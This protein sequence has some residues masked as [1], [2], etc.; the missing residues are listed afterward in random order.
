MTAAIEAR[1]V[2]RIYSTPEGSTAALQG[3]SLDIVE[4]E[5]V[6]VFGPSGSG[7]TTLL[8][9][10]A[11]LDVPSAG[12]VRVLG[13]DVGTLAGRP[14][15]RFRQEQIGYA[16]Q[17]YS[18]A[19]APE[20]Q[21]EELVGLRLRLAGGSSREAMRRAH[22][23]LERVGLLD[24]RRARPVELSGGEQQRVAVCAA[25]AHGPH[26]FLADEPT[27]EL[28]HANAVALY[29]L[30]SELVHEESCTAVVVSHDPEAT[31]IADR[32]VHLRD[33]RVS[34]EATRDAPT[35]EEI[36]VGRG[37][38][39]RLPETLLREASITQR[40][41]AHLAG[42]AI[43][44]RPR[45]ATAPSD[46]VRHTPAVRPERPQEVVRISGLHKTYGNGTRSRVVFQGLDTAFA[47]GCFSVVTGPSG[48]GKSS[49]LNLI[50][51]LDLPDTG[52]INVL[53]ERIVNLDRAER[54][55]YR[56]QA[57]AFVVQ[58]P[59]LISFLSALE[60]VQLGLLLRG[61]AD[62][63]NLTRAR[64]ALA[65]VGLEERVDTRTSRLSAGERQRV[66]IARALAAE[67]AVLLAD[68]PTA[69]LDQSNTMLL[70]ELL[71][72]WARTSG[73]AVIC[74]THDALLVEQADIQLDLSRARRI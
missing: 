64:L 63:E 44:I 34:T 30:M 17:H 42:D 21:V 72:A 47:G 48:S 45:G 67:P 32:I 74:A 10:L 3:L 7:K 23:L 66:A 70:A 27:G 38:W 16:D 58:D 13:S 69:R 18:R 36:V 41:A 46:D 8:R 22:E 37:G 52:E 60:N 25:L 53:G 12:S 43:V 35:N 49:L 11:G 56:S 54:A 26:L 33:G 71:T 4:N 14:L 5:V 31:T 50:A 61:R 15:A 68:E 29:G 2:F 1:D 55:A 59:A 39:M 51:G 57:I 19:L 28:D 24:R 62:G 20:L 73:A 9:M 65:A 40:A 6:V